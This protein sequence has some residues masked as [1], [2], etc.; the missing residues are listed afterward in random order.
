MNDIP[1]ARK[2]LS[3]FVNA[4]LPNYRM[5]ANEISGKG[6][7]LG[8]YATCSKDAIKDIVCYMDDVIGNVRIPEDFVNAEELTSNISFILEN[9]KSNALEKV[10]LTEE[11]AEEYHAVAI[12]IQHRERFRKV[13]KEFLKRAQNELND[14][15]NKDATL[16]PVSPIINIRNVNKQ[17]VSAESSATAETTTT[18]TSGGKANSW[19]KVATI[20]SVGIFLLA[21][22]T[23]LGIRSYNANQSNKEKSEDTQVDSETSLIDNSSKSNTKND[24]V[25]IKDEINK[26]DSTH[27]VSEK[28][29]E[30]KEDEQTE[31]IT[32]K[33]VGFE[34]VNSGRVYESKSFVDQETGVVF[35][36]TH[37]YE[38]SASV[39]LTLPGESTQLSP[40]VFPGMSWFFKFEGTE[41]K[42]IMSSVIDAGDIG[43]MSTDGE[44]YVLVELIKKVE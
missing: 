16:P 3:A 21:V 44:S 30:T 15:P 24:T 27:V 42:L 43:N 4:N 1:E 8:K 2:Y 35:A 29:M 17:S 18:S 10:N 39:N 12:T 14:K 7:H 20:A 6:Y 5:W 25:L 31:T 9:M 41:Y 23:W 38:N 26:V 19:Q 37:L 11:F 36:V 32:E 34:N 22:L 28:T 40:T 33:H 13:L